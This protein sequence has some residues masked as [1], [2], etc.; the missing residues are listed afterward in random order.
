MTHT[1][2]APYGPRIPTRCPS[3]MT[4]LGVIEGEILA[5]LDRHASASLRRLNLV[6]EWPAE[7]VMTAV[8]ALIR[9]GLVRGIQRNLEV[10]V[11]L[12]KPL[13]AAE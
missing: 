10:I 9:A 2:T 11:K 13:Y 6:V 5:Y 4:P 7:M 1:M 8:G 3:L 12:R